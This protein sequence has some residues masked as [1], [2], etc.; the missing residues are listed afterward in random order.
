L[1]VAAEPVALH[2]TLTT[3]GPGEDEGCPNVLSF[4]EQLSN[5][6]AMAI[7][8]TWFSLG[9]EFENSPALPVPGGWCL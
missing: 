7:F 6:T 2:V 5:R 4:G 1:Q 3:P 9:N 8:F